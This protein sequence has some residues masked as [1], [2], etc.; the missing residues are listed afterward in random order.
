MTPVDEGHTMKIA[1]IDYKAGNLRNVQ[2]AV[3]CLGRS[4]EVVREGTALADA[5]AMILPG[6]GAFGQGMDNLAR[7]GFVDA[8][9][10]EVL[11]KGKPILGICLGMHLVGTVGYEGGEFQGLGLLP[12]TVPRFDTSECGVRLPHIGWNS[13]DIT[14]GS[15]LFD[16]VP[17]GADFYFVHSYHVACEDES[18]IAARCGYC[19]PF[20][21]AVESGNVFATQFHPEKSQRYGLKV[22]ENF[23]RHCEGG[24]PC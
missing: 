2:K 7:A 3:E 11:E 10:R 24:R 20:A 13:V 14:P 21:A 12:M 18:M 8:M 1:I 19:Y 23:L 17:Q 9:R 6:V 4:A 16:G 22:L 15:M 5:G